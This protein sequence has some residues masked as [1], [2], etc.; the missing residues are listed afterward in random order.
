MT[1][2]F[3]GKT[4][5]FLKRQMRA[6]RMARKGNVAMIFALSVVPLLLAGGSGIDLARSLAVRGKL[7]A[8]VDAAAL[9]VASKTGIT[10][11]QAQILAQQYFD[12]NYKLDSSFG[13]PA[14]V[15]VTI[16]G[17]K[18]TVTSDI[19]M[20][21][22]LMNIAGIHNV[23]MTASSDV[24]WGQTKIWVG[25]ALDNTGSMCEPSASPCPTPGSNTKI[26]ALKNAT[27]SLLTMF[28]NASAN[29][30]DVRVSLVPFSRDVRIDTANSGASW[31]DWSE[32]DS[33]HGGTCS[34]S[35]YTTAAACGGAGSC[36]I[37]GKT[38]KST[39][40]AAFVGMCH[41][42]GVLR[43]DLTSSS[44]CTNG[45]NVGTCSMTSYS[46]KSTCE[47][48]G[49][50]SVAGYA[51]QTSCLAIGTCTIAGK[52]TKS[53][54]ETSYT[55]SC[56]LSGYANQS[57]C[58]A[59]G[60]CS[61]AG[62]I[63]KSACQSTYSGY[64]C[65]INGVNYTDATHDTSSECTNSVNG[66]CSKPQFTTQSTCVASKNPKGVWYVG[67]WTAV[68]SAG[69]WTPAVWTIAYGIWTPTPGT[70]TTG[71]WTATP[72][73]WSNS[74]GVWTA[75]PGTWAPDR[76]AWTGCITDR[77]DI[78]APSNPAYDTLNTTPGAADAS[79]FPASNHTACPPATLMG[80]GYDWTA[81]DTKVDTMVANGNTN[82][83]IGLAWA[84]QSLSQ[85]N[86]LNPPSLSTGTVRH[87]IILSDG[88]N[89]QN[90]WSS[91]RSTIDGRM[92]T[93]CTN[94]KNDDVII[95]SVFVNIAGTAGNA[96]SMK[97]CA[98]GGATG[99]HYIEVT[100][101]SGIGNAFNVI[102]QQI[103]NLRV[104]H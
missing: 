36:T 9:A 23:N 72:G 3:L 5:S 70:W 97:D 79:K 37:S 99:G 77:G 64:V 87:I 50:C 88:E 34:L 12:A 102:G 103:T 96:Q 75:T 60:T 44:A 67:T 7:Y 26:Y 43:A 82:Q 84:W 4:G 93:L 85:G 21:T 17:Q 46:T 61:I 81:L 35:S 49:A 69:V 71:V 74:Y 8:A 90:R 22:T 14:P 53:S 57:A 11:A 29:P 83:T 31:I 18:V 48:A 100:S 63:T 62:P 40:E 94:A 86:P 6:L 91:T 51:N 19:A 54:C 101:T 42:N 66:I 92:N 13:A 16:A 27:K 33:T 41:V 68:G 80:L 32:W 104:S 56:S 15:Q 65:K 52:T 59:A 1:S 39:C 45:N 76:S 20:P 2:N 78:G 10:Q 47:A 25:L 28:Q 58:Q 89:T 38:T 98:T 24:V 55:G 95:W 30:G 73:V